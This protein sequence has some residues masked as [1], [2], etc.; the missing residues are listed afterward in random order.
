[1][2][3]LKNDHIHI[4]VRMNI[5]RDNLN[6]YDALNTLLNSRFHDDRVHLYPAFV[7]DYS[8]CLLGNCFENKEEKAKFLKNLY[9][10]KGV[11]TN[12]L[13]PQRT[14][15]GCMRQ[16]LNSFVVGPS[17]ELYKC[18][19]HLGNKELEVGNVFG[20]PINY[21]LFSKMMVG[22]D[23]LF[24]DKCRKCVLFPSCDGGCSDIKE[25]GIDVC[26][27]AKAMLKDFL[28]IKYL[29]WKNANIGKQ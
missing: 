13:Y 15:K 24:D 27:P 11:Y 10:E 7:E 14:G 8:G 28:D 9:Y 16:T 18:W 3:L 1:M 2:V 4:S 6:E 29:Q 19:H 12:L 22:N 20:S 25:R 26:I 17:G 23:V 21:S 5:S